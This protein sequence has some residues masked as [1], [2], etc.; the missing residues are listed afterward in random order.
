[1]SGNHGSS[2]QLT[3]YLTAYLGQSVAHQD[4]LWHMRVIPTENVS[5]ALAR[6]DASWQGR[7]IASQSQGSGFDSLR[8]HQYFSWIADRDPQVQTSARIVDGSGNLEPGVQ[9]LCDS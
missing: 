9:L 5:H 8:E 3:A 6:P 4:A 7:S 2:H 1:M